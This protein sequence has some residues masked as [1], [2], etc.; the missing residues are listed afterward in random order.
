MNNIPKNATETQA[1]LREALGEVR[2][3]LEEVRKSLDAFSDDRHSVQAEE[4]PYLTTKD[5]TRRLHISKT[6]L[7]DLRRRGEIKAFNAGRRLL[8]KREDVDAFVERGAPV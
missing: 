3:E 7:W 2:D 1:D 4:S 8:F 5:V 6:T